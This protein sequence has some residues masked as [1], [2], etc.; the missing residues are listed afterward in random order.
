L[1]FIADYP[2]RPIKVSLNVTAPAVVKYIANPNSHLNTKYFLRLKCGYG[3]L[4][5]RR[6]YDNRYGVLDVAGIER[7]CGWRRILLHTYG[8]KAAVRAQTAVW[9]PDECQG[10]PP[11]WARLVHVE[12]VGREGMPQ[13]IGRHFSCQR[14]TLAAVIYG[15]DLR[16]IIPAGQSKPSTSRMGVGGQSQS[17][18]DARLGDVPSTVTMRTVLF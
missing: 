18:N 11:L 13:F 2:E 8:N 16:P 12:M 7:R 9:Q 17:S 5:R 10:V 15:A 6:T 1:N 14:E 3:P 4:L